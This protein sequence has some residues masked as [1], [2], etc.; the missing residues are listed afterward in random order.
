VT[1][2]IPRWFTHP[3]TVTHPS[4]NLATDDWES[5]LRP[6]DYKSGTLTVT[7]PSHLVVVVLLL[8]VIRY[9]NRP[10]MTFDDAGCTVVVLVVVVVIVVVV[11]VVVVICYQIQEPTGDDV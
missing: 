10:E 2:Y 11:V 9:K 6:V 7:L 8:C 4:T 3:Q 5:S 1:G